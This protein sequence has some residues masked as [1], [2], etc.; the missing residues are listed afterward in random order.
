MTR[1]SYDRNASTTMRELEVLFGKHDF[2]GFPVVEEGKMLGIVTQFDFCD[3]LD[4]SRPVG[5]PL[6]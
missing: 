4:H 1:A 2:N 3:P 6:R 5:P